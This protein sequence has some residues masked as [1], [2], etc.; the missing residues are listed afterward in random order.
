[1]ISPPP[2]SDTSAR[3]FFLERIFERAMELKAKHA[4]DHATYMVE[5][6]KL[7]MTNARNEDERRTW[8]SMLKTTQ[9]FQRM[10]QDDEREEVIKQVR[11]KLKAR[12]P[13]TRFHV[14]TIGPRSTRRWGV[15]WSDGPSE[16]EIKEL[17]APFARKD[18]TFELARK[19]TR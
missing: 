3:N 5:L 14:S 2:P 12:H 11:A 19:V 18:L 6:S 17:V 7:L 13:W 1:M 10:D 4:G 16:A 9:F 15:W 8:E